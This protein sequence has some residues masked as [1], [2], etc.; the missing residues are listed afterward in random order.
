MRFDRDGLV[1]LAMTGGYRYALY[2]ML[3]DCGART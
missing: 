3:L 2:G 1:L